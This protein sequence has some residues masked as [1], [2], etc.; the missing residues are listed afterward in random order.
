MRKIMASLDVG[1][2]TIKLVV[3]EMIKDKL[4][5][6][7]VSEESSKGVKKGIIV[8][9][10]AVKDS[11]KKVIN[12]VETILGQKIKK[13]ITTVP[14]QG[15][16]FIVN[17][18]SIEIESEDK[19]VRSSD[20]IKVIEKSI[21]HKIPN[22]MELVNITPIAFQIDDN[23]KTNNPKNSLANKLSVKTIA[24]IAPK[25][26]VYPIIECLEELNIEVLDIFYQVEGD[27]HE[28]KTAE[29][30]S[31]LGAVINIGASLTSLAIFNKGV[32]TNT[33]NLDVGSNNIDNDIS[34]IYKI[35]K[36]L[37]KELKEN[38]ALAHNRLADIK[39]KREVTDKDSKNII[40]D[41]Y[42]LSEIVMSRLIEILS[43]AKKEITLLT[44]KEISYI[45]ITGGITE[46]TD[47]SL[48]LEEVFGHKV[49]L[50]NI[51][52]IGARHNKFSSSLGLIKLY[53]KK[54][55]LKDKDYSIF[56]IE[57]QEEFSGINKSTSI[58]D[59]TVL[60]KIFC[61]FFD[62]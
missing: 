19:V 2:N 42:Q 11:L 50:G 9:K 25:Q 52:E 12:D 33:K 4:N 32:L 46:M 48:L 24:T 56:T 18:A 40:I 54:A 38:L 31:S 28:F 43:Q 41:Q 61:Y 45:I 53:H 58:H 62:N 44:K 13:L 16:E 17:E 27:Y 21:H 8:D 47:F 37:A 36:T 26:M 60:G 14:S 57:E 59:N 20:I 49:I 39:N 6:L 1:T 10:N 7:A 34:Y 22:N 15:N 5:I 3:G 23:Q 55:K 30:D 35:P 29:T 51:K